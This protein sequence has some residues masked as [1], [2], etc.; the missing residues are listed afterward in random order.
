MATLTGTCHCGAAHW[1]VDGDP[2][3]ATMCNCTMCRRLGAMWA[4]DYENERMR[5]FGPMRAYRRADKDFPVLE[6]LFCPTCANVIAWRGKR[7]PDGRK[8]LAVN[9]R[10]AEPDLVA[11]LPIDHFEGLDTF[12]D[13]PRD[14]RCVKDMW[15]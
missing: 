12:K 14:G 9:L 6:V 3:P 8:R 13:L 2:G 1:E 5:V 11:H 10:L 4:Y 7:E 15:F